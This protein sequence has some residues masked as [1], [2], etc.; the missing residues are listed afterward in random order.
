M[1]APSALLSGGVTA[2]SAAGA[3]AVTK[4]VDG[5]KIERVFNVKNVEEYI[6]R[7][8]EMIDRKKPL[9]KTTAKIYRK[10]E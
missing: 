4:I 2:P 1:T 7:I 5:D 9:S 8:D 6:S 10:Q 3:G